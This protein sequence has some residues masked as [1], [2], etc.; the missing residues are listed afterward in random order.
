MEI[1]KTK[2][3]YKSFNKLAKNIQELYH[4]QEDRFKNNYKDQR[5]HV[6]K[7]KT[8]K[9]A[10]PFRVTRSYRVFFFLKDE[11][12]AIFFEID[13]RKDAYR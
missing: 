2:E 10:F 8:L 11:I 5:L 4:K 6:K 12:T 3:F 9:R 1:I 13:H 7:V